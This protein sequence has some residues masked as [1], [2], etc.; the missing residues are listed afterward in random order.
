MS[1]GQESVSQ[2]PHAVYQRSGV[3]LGAKN[4]I[5]TLLRG[6]L[7]DAFHNIH[8]GITAENCNKKFGITRE[9]QD[10]QATH[11]QK[12]AEIAQKNGYFDAEIVAVP[13]RSRS[14]AIL[15]DKD[16]PRHGTTAETLSR[17]EPR[18]DTNGTVTAGNASG[19]ND[20]AAAVLLMSESEG[21][22]LKLKPLAKILL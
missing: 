17:L 14:G 19:M 22:N 11:S 12:M 8:M 21:K 3:K 16:E 7:T 5:D 4:L 9:Q 6:G 10:E 20:S 15:L 1:G 13:V 18:F 2:A